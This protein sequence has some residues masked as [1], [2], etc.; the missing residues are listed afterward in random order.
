MKLK[1]V[2]VI[3]SIIFTTAIFCDITA[4]AL[5]YTESNG[6]VT[7]ADGETVIGPFAFYERN[8]ITSVTIPD[9]VT[10]I[11]DAAF[12][13]CTNLKSVYVSDIE[14]WCNIEF[15][16]SAN[17]LQY[18]G[19][20]YIDNKIARDITIPDSITKINDVAFIGCSSITS[21][22][23]PDS[24][25]SI[26]SSAF[27]SC[28][29]LTCIS[30]SKNVTD[31][32][33]YVFAYCENLTKIVIPDG[34]T[35][36][37]RTAFTSSGLTDVYYYGTEA[38]WTNIAGVADNKELTSV[39]V[40]YVADEDILQVTSPANAKIVG[41]EIAVTVANGVDSLS[42]AVWVI[43]GTTWGLYRTETATKPLDNNTV[44]SLRE[45]RDNVYYIK[46]L[47]ADKTSTKTYKLTIYR[48]TKSVSPTISANRDVV[49]ISAENSDIY[50]TLD[51]STPT[52]STLKYTEAFSAPSNAVIKAIAKQADKDEFSNVV[53]YTVPEYITTSIDIID[54]YMDD[55]NFEYT[56]YIISDGVPSGTFIVAVYDD[57]GRMLGVKL[58]DV[59]IEGE[60]EVANFVEI[61]GTPHTY[62][63]FFWNSL[64]DLV[65]LCNNAEGTIIK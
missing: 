30:M 15:G 58:E 39:T 53:E 11:D 32:G 5:E 26:G 48:N 21:I 33:T 8:D 7:I 19:T 27:S 17:P 51:G 44:T 57:K 63:V 13:G 2:F 41:N 59:T 43:D 50:Y 24:V 12:D 56:F 23:L 62:K 34:V 38:E 49:T 18:G 6:H 37:N 35:S 55:N 1:K 65:P 64:D 47:S 20:L 14:S 42:V 45:G 22:I 36:I 9:S 25:T 31:I 10:K 61:K 54:C 40:H 29:N 60:G 3:A 52:E 46:T 4:N 28:C 16:G